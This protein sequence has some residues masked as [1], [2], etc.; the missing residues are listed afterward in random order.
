M[1]LQRRKLSPV[2]ARWEHADRWMPICPRLAAHGFPPREC[3]ILV[4]AGCELEVIASL[5]LRFATNKPTYMTGK[6]QMKAN[7]WK[8]L[9]PQ[10]GSPGYS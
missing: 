4:R 5:V 1:K 9:G 2:C 7:D 6:V 8:T 3:G 10:N